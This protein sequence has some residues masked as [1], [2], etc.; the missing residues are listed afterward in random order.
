[1]FAGL[2]TYSLKGRFQQFLTPAQDLLV[3]RRI[4]ANQIT[5]GTFFFSILTTSILFLL[6]PSSPFA[7][8]LFLAFFIRMALNALDGM[9]ARKTQSSSKKGAFLNELTDYLCDVYLVFALAFYTSEATPLW[10]AFGILMVT[11]EFISSLFDTNSPKYKS[12]TGPM[13]KSDR[14][15]FFSFCI[16]AALMPQETLW[17]ES[18][19]WTGCLLALL[20]CYNRITLVVRSC[21]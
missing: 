3:A 16:I 10:I 4:T 11:S 6:P 20:T 14:T 2:S 8:L 7:L 5:L 19:L 21:D 9:I 17:L 12:V 13:S 18:V 1:M 15:V